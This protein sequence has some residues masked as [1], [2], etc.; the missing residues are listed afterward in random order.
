MAANGFGDRTAVGSIGSGLTYAQLLDHAA[1][2]GHS[3]D[4]AGTERV[5]FL[6]VTSPALPVALFGAAYAGQPFVP[7]NY[8][9]ADGDLAQ[10]AERTAPASLVA[11]ADQNARVAHVDG[12]TI[13]DRDDFMET[14]A[15]GDALEAGSWPSDPDDIAVLLYTS[16]TTG[17]PKAAVLRHNCLLYTSPSPRD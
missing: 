16:G 12:L 2:A 17:S 15:T 6:D 14:A 9:L 4:Q 13:A 3:F 10:L 8:R 5:S 1:R 7:L 11:G